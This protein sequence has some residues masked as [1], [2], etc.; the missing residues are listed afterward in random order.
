MITSHTW[1]LRYWEQL[2][3]TQE[4]YLIS[5]IFSDVYSKVNRNIDQKF[6]IDNK[7]TLCLGIF[8]LGRKD[9]SGKRIWSLA[10]FFHIQYQI[11]NWRRGSF[12]DYI[13]KP[14]ICIL[15]SIYVYNVTHIIECN[16]AIYTQIFE[17]INVFP[18][19]G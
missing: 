8:T 6:G 3:M 12:K 10:V 1:D 19:V 13:I 9:Y 2:L 15:A 4:A 16:I 14:S 11:Q 5:L 7:P 17:I 18:T